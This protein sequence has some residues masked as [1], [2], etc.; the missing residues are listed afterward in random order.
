MRTQRDNDVVKTF[1]TFRGLLFILN[2]FI[3][4]DH[5]LLSLSFYMET[6]SV[7]TSK[8]FMISE[9]FLLFPIRFISSPRAND[10]QLKNNKIK[11]KPR[12]L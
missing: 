2:F 5:K 8:H 12:L 1:W 11:I 9:M 6:T 10:F 7:D 3:C 4:D